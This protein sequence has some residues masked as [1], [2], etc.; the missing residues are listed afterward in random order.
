MK[1]MVFENRSIE[2]LEREYENY[3]IQVPK[4]LE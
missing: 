1:E 2:K 4:E 3:H